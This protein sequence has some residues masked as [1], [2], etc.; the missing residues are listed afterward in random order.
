[1]VIPEA[2]FAGGICFSLL[3]DAAPGCTDTRK[4]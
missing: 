1:M 2:P 3:A 4:Y